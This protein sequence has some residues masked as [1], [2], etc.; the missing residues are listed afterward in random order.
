[1]FRNA[2]AGLYKLAGAHLVRQQI[3]A[4]F[5][6]PQVAYDIDQNYLVVWPSPDYACEARYDLEQ[7]GRLLV[8]QCP[9]PEL[10]TRLPVLDRA[11]VIFEQHALRWEQWR[12]CWDQLQRNP[13][14]VPPLLPEVPLLPSQVHWQAEV[15]AGEA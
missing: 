11:E 5:P 15:S 8:P 14:E 3:E 2:V 6:W 10:R 12:A 7:P 1:M 13:L 4:A 9:E